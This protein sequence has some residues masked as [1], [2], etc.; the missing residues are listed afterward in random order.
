MRDVCE[1][2]DG[3]SPSDHEANARLRT[4]W[5]RA[6]LQGF[7]P[8]NTSGGVCTLARSAGSARP[9]NVQIDYECGPLRSDG[10]R[11]LL[12]IHRAWQVHIYADKPRTKRVGG[13]H[14]GGPRCDPRHRVPTRC[15][16][17]GQVEG[18][19]HFIFADQGLG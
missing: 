10:Y 13:V 18:Y 3:G 11:R 12:T 4:S 15:E 5:R 14:P 1:W 16:P 17:P 19:N 7:D 2:R 6:S 8:V 9:F